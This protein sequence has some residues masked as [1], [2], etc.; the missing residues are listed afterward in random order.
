MLQQTQVATVLARFYEPFLNRFPTIATLAAASEQEVLQQWQGLGYYSRAR[1]LHAAARQIVASSQPTDASGWRALPGIGQNTANAI[2]AFAHHQPVAILE[3]NV[4]RVACRIFALQQPT[5]AQCWQAA[6]ALLN[7][8]Q[9][10][11]HNQAMMDLGS[12]ICTPRTPNC[13]QCPAN[14]I[15]Q[16]KTAPEFFPQKKDQSPPADP[17][18]AHYCVT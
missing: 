12:Q 5:P 2:A 9:P 11:D 10:F 4:K 6:E 18:K 3:A 7:P 14:T 17:A 8:Q 1:N 15:C 16:G 13:P